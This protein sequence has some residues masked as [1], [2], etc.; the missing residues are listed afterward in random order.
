MPIATAAIPTRLAT[1]T[2]RRARARLVDRLVV[3]AAVEVW[4]WVFISRSVLV[5]PPCGSVSRLPG[6]PPSRAP[7]DGGQ[8]VLS[9]L[10]AAPLDGGCGR[11][12]PHR[13]PRERQA[14]R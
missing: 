9:V 1:P 11:P 6:R 2:D 4:G 3:R 8:R 12:A 14:P 13:T 7:R 5:E 10:S